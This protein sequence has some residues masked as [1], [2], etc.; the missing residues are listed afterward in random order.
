MLDSVPPGKQATI[1]RH[2]AKGAVRQ[3][4]LDLGFIP[5]KLVTVVRRAPLGDPVQCRVAGYNVT[6]RKTEAALIEIE[7]D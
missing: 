5:G 6:L 7:E 1:K 3:R 4:L 2:H